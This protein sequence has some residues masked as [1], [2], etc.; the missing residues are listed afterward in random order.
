MADGLRCCIW[1]RAQSPVTVSL[2]I[3]KGWSNMRREAPKGNL[4]LTMSGVLGADCRSRPSSPGYQTCISWRT[5][6]SVS[7]SIIT[8]TG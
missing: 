8:L 1:A 3:V 4:G 6:L 2:N 5:R 7:S